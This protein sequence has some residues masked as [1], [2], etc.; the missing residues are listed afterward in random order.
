MVSLL[1]PAGL[2]G[3]HELLLFV[4]AVFVLNATPGVDL[5]LTVTRTLQGGARAGL[6][7]ALGINAGCVLHALAAAFGLAALLA[8]SAATFALVKWAGAAYLLW[9]AV[10]M[11]RQAWAGRPGAAASAAAT[12]RRFGADF[13]AGLLTNLLNPKVVL[14]FLAFL[15]QFIRPETADKTLA[16]L[17]LGAVFVVQSTVFL[18]AVVAL[19][20]RARR[21]AMSPPLARWLQG[22]GGLLF[23]G[24]ALRLAL[25]PHGKA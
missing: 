17:L 12:P 4:A 11:W 9:L 8:V 7:A 25:A 3:P 23:A 22:L 15:P 10:G 20:A 19:A 21:A 1:G 18:A 24:L 16:F 6:A 2:G 14:F 5:L 13:R